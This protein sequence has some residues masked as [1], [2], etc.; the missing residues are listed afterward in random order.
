MIKNNKRIKLVIAAGVCAF[1]GLSATIMHLVNTNN[2]KNEQ[3]AEVSKSEE[4]PQSKD[5]EK[6]MKKVRLSLM[7]SKIQIK[8]NQKANRQIMLKNLQKVKVSKQRA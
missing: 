4:N 2:N 7:L 8:I 6:I 3:S 5:D 1:I